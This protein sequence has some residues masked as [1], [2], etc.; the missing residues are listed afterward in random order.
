MRAMKIQL[1]FFA[2]A[3][4]A[5]GHGTEEI[6]VGPRASVQQVLEVLSQR[7]PKLAPLRDSLRL[8]VNEDF[9]GAAHLLEEGDRLALLPPVSGG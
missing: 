9:V 3:R 8:A 4:E 2:A 6:E 5:V 1:L 7:H